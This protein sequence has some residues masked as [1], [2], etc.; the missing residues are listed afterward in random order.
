MS[1]GIFGHLSPDH[2]ISLSPYLFFKYPPITLSPHFF[3]LIS[4]SPISLSLYLLFYVSLS[5]RPF[6]IYGHA[7]R[8]RLRAVTPARRRQALRRAGTVTSFSQGL[9]SKYKKV[10]CRDLK[11][12]SRIF[13]SFFNPVNNAGRK[14]FL[15]FY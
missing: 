11:T 6:L 1:R 3:I 14:E 7:T 5:P 13:F 4:S 12:I 2:P 10:C 15:F 8:T 9:S